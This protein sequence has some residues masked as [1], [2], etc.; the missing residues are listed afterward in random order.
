MT[1]KSKRRNSQVGKTVELEITDMAHGGQAIGRRAGRPVFVPYT[2]PG[3]S[4]TAQIT[5]QRG[6]ALFAQGRQLKA[7][8]ADRVMPPCP[9]F[10]PGRC[11][12]C[13]WQHIRYPAQ[14]LLKQDVLADQLMRVGGLPERLIESTL[15][16]VAAAPREWAYNHRLKLIRGQDG[17]WGFRQQNGR[18]IEAITECR[19]A[20]PELLELLAELDLEYDRARGMILQRG[21]D[22]RMM[23]IFELEDEEAPRL[24]TDLP[25]SVNLILPSNEPINLIGSAHSLFHIGQRDF[26]VTAGAYIRPNISQIDRLTAEVIQGLRLTG[27]ERTLDLYGGVGIFSAF[28]A[29]RA[30][31]VTLI[32]SYPPAVSDAD[33]NLME[34]DNLDIVEGQ[35]ERVLTDMAAR[36]ASYDAAVVDPPRSGLGKAVIKNLSRLHVK[37]LVYVSDEPAALARDSKRLMS[38][39][40]RLQ[41]VQPLDL[42]PQTYY[43]HA[44]ALFER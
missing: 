4:I 43:I 15:R 35:V 41:K 24:K 26:R 32:E 23:L 7:A 17:Q 1:G 5:G 2:L 18:G 31:T 20:H 40:F 39:G 33:V 25:L 6:A 8:S 21:S 36:R 42:A 37:R 10:G 34:Y 14:L 9:H 16:P 28:M 30:A 3:E 38:A 44:V 11:W 13:H 12:G 27:Q 19:L 22:G 29:P